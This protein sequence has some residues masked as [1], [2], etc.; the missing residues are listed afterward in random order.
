MW[1]MT[2]IKS[3]YQLW[4]GTFGRGFNLIKIVGGICWMVASLP[5]YAGA[6][7]SPG[8]IAL[9]GCY[10]NWRSNEIVIGNTRFEGKWN[11]S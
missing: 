1:S 9:N 3:I 7:E 10:A 2:G 8:Q 5:Q 11:G 6:T 4:K